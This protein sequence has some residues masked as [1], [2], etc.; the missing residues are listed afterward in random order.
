MEEFIV[1]ISKKRNLGITAIPY[2]AI[3]YEDKPIKLQEQVTK[4]HLLSYPE[5]FNK[6][7]E[8]V[9]KLLYSIN[10]KEL[11]RVYAPK[12][13]LKDFITNLPDNARYNSQ[14][15][16]KIDQ[17]LYDTIKI[18]ANSSIKVYYKESFYNSIYKSDRLYISPLPLE[19]EFHFSMLFSTEQKLLYTL[20]LKEIQKKSQTHQ[21]SINL[22]G[23]K[24]QFISNKT[25]A[26]IIENTLYWLNKGESAK[27]KP[28]IEKSEIII[29]GDKIPQYMEGF[30]KKIIQ[31]F[32]TKA[33]GFSIVEQFETPSPL[34]SLQKDLTGNYVLNLSFKYSN[35]TFLADSCS[36]TFVSFHTDKQEY[37]FKVVKRD[38][39]YE[40]NIRKVLVDNGLKNSDNKIDNASFIVAENQEHD[41]KDKYVPQ[42]ILEWI[43]KKRSL[44]EKYNILTELEL[45]NRKVYTGNFKIDIDQEEVNDWF[46]IKV[47]IKTDNY[48]IPF[49][50]L[51]KNIKENNPEYILPN[52]TI[53]LIPAEWFAQLN[54]IDNYA[55]YK[56]DSIIISRVHYR[57]VEDLHK[58]IGNKKNSKE[59]SNIVFPETSIPGNINATLRPYQVEG[60][61]WL[62]FLNENSF[63]GILAD[64]MGL[65][66][67]LQTITLL[68]KIYNQKNSSELSSNNFNKSCNNSS[69]ENL[70]QPIQ[71]ALFDYT[72]TSSLNSTNI[73]ASLIV[74][75]TSLI[76]NWEDEIKK[77]APLLRV[78]N[79]TGS[80]RLRSQ[81]IVK[82]FRHYHIIL[83]T[84]GTVR[85]D[86][87][88]LEHYNFYYLI[89]DESQYVKNPSS[90]TYSAVKSINA[91]KRVTLTGTPIENSLTDLWTQMNFV[92]Q[93]L[94]GSLAFFK[95]HFII[96]VTK[97]R[98]ESK[99]QKLQEL[100][101]P[102]ILRRRKEDVAQDLPPIMEQVLYCDMTTEQQNYYER[103]KSGI[104]NQIYKA[105]EDGRFEKSQI[106][107]LESLVKLRQIANHPV[108]VDKSYKGSSG[109]F[110][111]ILDSM[112]EII[113]EN[114][115]ILLFSSF[116]KDLEL[117]E[118][119]LIK[120]G[121]KYSKLTGSTR[122]RS[123]V[124]EK[125]KKES[126]VF[127]ISLK[128]GGTGLNLTKAD[129]VFMLNPW[130]NPAAESQAVSRAHRIGQTKNVFVYKFLSVNTIEEKIA[131]LQQRKNKLADTFINNNNPFK[132][133]THKE[134]IELFK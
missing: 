110:E 132:D 75:P 23:K 12:E 16:P 88:F 127:L 92:N 46:D 39:E 10:E 30:V 126:S 6:K 69:E 106:F 9:I 105:I 32:N 91:H 20:K 51:R 49:K 54:E 11:K 93:G 45:N 84:Y 109:K 38:F 116:V 119:E 2:H 4:K 108:M 100:I 102:F 44:I 128:A 123:E 47:T 72:P 31:N 81:D 50:K 43:K 64:D 29:P 74:M 17:K 13:S 121:I 101:K 7:E 48:T 33:E 18:V 77:F 95:R 114:H 42:L 76:H 131:K 8:A 52:G 125:F 25:A 56:N 61:K 89:L 120:K 82:I 67:T 41:I 133:L 53:F 35:G 34:L 90:K 111:Q 124:I 103:E 78:Y 129:Y 37:L 87:S 24:V 1:V 134:I 73:P 86:L 55:K 80:D 60:Y 66:K 118:K 117:I 104:R 40:A 15:K 96:P 112:E 22:T 21:K 58:N 70:K 130:W 115:N 71:Q 79:Y 97:K 59:I 83:T 85:N 19:P 65:G 99:Q 98:D 27:L 122:N 68:Q 26:F 107:A 36:N 28:F 113:S 94:L 63:G 3:I 14:I 57:L 5:H 62:N